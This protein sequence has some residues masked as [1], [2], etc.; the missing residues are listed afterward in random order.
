MGLSMNEQQKTSVPK[1]K[2]PVLTKIS[3]VWLFLA[4]II[5]SFFLSG[6]FSGSLIPGLVAIGFFVALILYWLPGMFLLARR[7]WGWIVAMLLLI[8]YVIGLLVWI[9]AYIISYPKNPDII[10]YVVGCGGVLLPLI[11][12][13]IDSRNYFRMIRQRK[14]AEE[15]EKSNP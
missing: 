10:V 14:L 15:K 5:G 11:L 2:F 13:L 3:I 1:A 7:R 6:A 4:P 8:T 9:I 12:T